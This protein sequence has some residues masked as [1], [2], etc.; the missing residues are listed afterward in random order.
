[1]DLS[2]LPFGLQVRGFAAGPGG[3]SISLAAA[4]LSFRRPA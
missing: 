3:V 1:V 2:G 4:G